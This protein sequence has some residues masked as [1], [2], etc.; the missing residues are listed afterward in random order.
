MVYEVQN[1]INPSV[2]KREITWWSWPLSLFQMS[3]CTTTGRAWLELLRLHA[4]KITYP[5]VSQH[6]AENTQT[7]LMLVL[8]NGRQFLKME[9]NE[10]NKDEK[11]KKKRKKIK[12]GN[13]CTTEFFCLRRIILCCHR[14]LTLSKA[15]RKQN[16]FSLSRWQLI[17]ILLIFADLK[18]K[19]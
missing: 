7:A 4:S 15:L 1:L 10:K 3:K 6:R 16:F 19:I 5:T 12:S 8:G 14:K 11:K 13:N 18:M 17:K 2:V 9:E